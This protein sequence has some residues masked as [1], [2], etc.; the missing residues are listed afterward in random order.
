MDNSYTTEEILDIGAENESKRSKRKR[1]GKI[2]HIAFDIFFA[3]LATVAFVFFTYFEC[4]I[5]S[6]LSKP[7]D[8]AT[9]FGVAFLLIF[10]MVCGIA[11]VV[12]SAITVILSGV[13]IKIQG[14]WMRKVCVV[15]TGV[16]ASIILLTCVAFATGFIIGVAKGVLIV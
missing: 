5:Y 16:F 3:V 13:G 9:G 14:G 10:A 8:G 12:V 2:V 1:A 4:G 11:T 15:L 6:I 7:I